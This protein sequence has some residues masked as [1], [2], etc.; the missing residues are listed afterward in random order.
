[1][2]QKK[3]LFNT[4]KIEFSKSRIV[5][6]DI[7]CLSPHGADCLSDFRLYLFVLALKQ[8]SKENYYRIPSFRPVK[9]YRSTNCILDVANIVNA[10]EHI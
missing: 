1:M 4:W 2:S 5:H 10:P 7:N 9:K 8:Y 6:Y 3:K